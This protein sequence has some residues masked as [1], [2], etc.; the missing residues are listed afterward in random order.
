MATPFCVAIHSVCSMRA[1]RAGSFLTI[2]A[3]ALIISHSSSEALVCLC[4]RNCPSGDVRGR[5]APS[6]TP[7]HP[8][9][10]D[11]PPERAPPQAQQT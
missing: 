6:R 1:A 11:A 10:I 2:A 8:V 5:P 9:V 7:P 3:K 4:L